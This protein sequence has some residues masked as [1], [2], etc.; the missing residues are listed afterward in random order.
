MVNRNRKTTFVLG[1]EVNLE[2]SHCH[3]LKFSNPYIITNWMGKPLIF[4]AKI[5][6]SN[7]IYR[8]QYL[9]STTLGC[10]D[11]RN[12]KS[13]FELIPLKGMSSWFQMTFHCKLDRRRRSILYWHDFGTSEVLN[14][15][16]RFK[17]SL[18][19][20]LVWRGRGKGPKLLIL[21]CGQTCWNNFRL[22][23][24]F[25]DLRLFFK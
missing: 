9:R 2:L 15:S 8:F 3:K 21:I 12:R 22:W 11:I 1:Q 5:I 7:K 6:Q 25:D 17:S 14:K 4:Q 10:K 23:F 19:F 18:K 13:E 20:T 24:K 16:I